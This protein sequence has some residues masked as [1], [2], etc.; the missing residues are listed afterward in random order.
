M[1]RAGAYYGGS[2]SAAV[3][4]AMTA[5]ETSG[6]GCGWGAAGTARLNG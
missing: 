5:N 4:E 3:A 1:L 2:R 6:F